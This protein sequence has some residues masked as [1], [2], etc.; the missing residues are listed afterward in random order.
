MISANC[1]ACATRYRIPDD[2]AGKPVRCRRCGETFHAPE[3]EPAASA[4]T[5]PAESVNAAGSPV[6]AGE[7]ADTVE[8]VRIE[9]DHCGS[10]LKVPARAAGRRIKCPKCSHVLLVP[11]AVTQTEAT[12][13]PAS[14]I[15][16]DDFL[17]DLTA[18][19]RSGEAIMRVAPVAPAA[20]AAPVLA[21]GPICP[22]C[23]QHQ[24]EGAKICT[25][26]GISLKTGRS[27]MMTSDEGVERAC[28]L[29][30]N[31]IRLISWIIG[32]GIYPIASEA[33]GTAKPYVIRAIALITI[34]TSVLFF[35]YACNE[36]SE[37]RRGANLMLWTGD[38]A[39]ALANLERMRR[40]AES[41]PEA[42]RP[43]VMRRLAAAEETVAATGE[44]HWYQLIT[45]AFLHGG[46]LHLASNL[47]FLMVLGTRVNALVGNLWALGLYP[48]LAIA[49][50]W[51]YLIAS[52]AEWPHPMVG[53][54][55]AIMG[56][57][58]MYIVL[59]PAHKVHMAAWWRWSL[60]GGFHLSLKI[61]T[62]RGF[63]VVMFYIA[64]D[65]VFTILGVKDNV[66]HWA[67]LG[68][69]IAGICIATIVLVSRLVN[70]RGG[71]LFSVVLGRRAW[72][73]VGRPR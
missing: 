42:Q 45:Y 61:F 27:I 71:D 3:V 68:G 25:T 59:F 14:G 11:A 50:G 58:G 73:I 32:F 38:R 35:A 1:P 72:A 43:Y 65:I 46:I 30:E 31:T 44:F 13:A 69:F 37:S 51:A 23:K 29:A 54:S 4:A 56:L 2:A 66:A 9:C 21:T 52:A 20:V 6:V 12:A 17:N 34:A 24:P 18:A 47:L 10:R 40:D 39:G 67:H 15:S 55:G 64:F 70:A 19:E 53:A 41:V 26:C 36:D 33:F 57:A 28:E 8:P 48:L 63:W 49:S 60:I 5:A 7:S 16:D 62:M 22:S